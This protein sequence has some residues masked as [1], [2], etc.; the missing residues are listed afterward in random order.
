M[1]H[2]Q[3]LHGTP[4]M[5]SHTL[6]GSVQLTASCELFRDTLCR[7]VHDS[8]PMQSFIA[9]CSAA[10]HGSHEALM[11]STTTQESALDDADVAKPQ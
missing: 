8:R 2:L 3:P 5:A 10:P 9:T 6:L 11:C 1:V 4:L 7:S